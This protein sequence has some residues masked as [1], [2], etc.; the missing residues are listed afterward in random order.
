[1]KELQIIDNADAV[2][3]AF[4]SA[5]RNGDI[6]AREYARLLQFEKKLSTI[7][8]DRKIREI[9]LEEFSK[10]PEKEGEYKGVKWIYKNGSGRYGYEH[11]EEWQKLKEQEEKMSEL[12]KQLEEKMKAAYKT[13]STIIDEETGEIIPPATYTAYSDS[14]SVK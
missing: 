8:K 10:Y 2:I 9:A 11:S 5:L 1:M 3:S 13:S 4:K 7:T 14:I 12:R 6:D